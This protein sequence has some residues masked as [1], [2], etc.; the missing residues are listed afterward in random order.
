LLRRMHLRIYP[1]MQLLRSVS[2]RRR[3]NLGRWMSSL[4]G[5]TRRSRFLLTQLKAGD[6]VAARRCSRF[7]PISRPVDE[8]CLPGAALPELARMCTISW[9]RSSSSLEPSHLLRFGQRHHV[10][11]PSCVLWSRFMKDNLPADNFISYV[12]Q[13]FR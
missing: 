6:L 1:L 13:S 2:T 11:R 5:R 3:T 4:G 9:S 8:R 10:R 7:L 12:N